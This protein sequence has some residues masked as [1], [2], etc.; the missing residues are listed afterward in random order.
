MKNDKVENPYKKLRGLSIGNKSGII[1]V[2]GCHGAQGG[3]DYTAGS[4]GLSE[5]TVFSRGQDYIV[6]ASPDKP[7]FIQWLLI[8]TAHILRNKI[9]G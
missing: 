3:F 4:P 8:A 1:V 7:V 2:S 6:I 9:K 5:T